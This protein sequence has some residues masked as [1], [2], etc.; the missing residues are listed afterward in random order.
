[1]WERGFSH[2]AAVVLVLVLILLPRSPT[3]GCGNSWSNS[4]SNSCSNGRSGSP[5]PYARAPQRQSR[6]HPIGRNEEK[7]FHRR[8]TLLKQD[9]VR[10]RSV[11]EKQFPTLS[12]FNSGDKAAHAGQP[13]YIPT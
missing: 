10:L 6:P 3:A 9:E 1:M 5:H 4:W 2:S 8:G 12:A 11:R 7:G 13:D